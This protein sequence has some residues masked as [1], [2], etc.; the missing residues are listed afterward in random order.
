MARKTQ[1]YTLDLSLY[2]S[3]F[4][5]KCSAFSS[6]FLGD[7]PYLNGIGPLRSPSVEDSTR[8]DMS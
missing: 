1:L 4:C 5:G 6:I 3:A 2:R 7:S 8:L